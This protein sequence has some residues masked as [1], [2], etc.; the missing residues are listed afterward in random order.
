MV[1]SFARGTPCARSAAQHEA[2][3]EAVAEAEDEAEDETKDETEMKAPKWKQSIAPGDEPHGGALLDV[4]D[5]G[6]SQNELS[7]DVIDELIFMDELV[8]V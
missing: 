6:Q 4:S 8:L 7:E 5:D 2:K 1:L 3:G